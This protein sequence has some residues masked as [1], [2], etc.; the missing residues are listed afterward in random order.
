MKTKLSFQRL[1]CG[2]QIWKPQY[3]NTISQLETVQHK[4]LSHMSY[5]GGRPILSFSHHY[6]VSS[7]RYLLPSLNSI[8][9]INDCKEILDSLPFDTRNLNLRYNLSFYLDFN[10]RR[11]KINNPI[12]RICIWVNDLFLKH[13]DI[14]FN[15]CLNFSDYSTNIIVKKP[16]YDWI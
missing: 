15:E 9:V 8:F 12:T 16:R 7:K 2:A 14:T 13:R 1:T 5:I 3:L 10:T 11:Y 6:S 4:F